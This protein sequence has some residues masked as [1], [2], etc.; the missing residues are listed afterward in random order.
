MVCEKQH[1]EVF[2]KETD[3]DAHSLVFDDLKP[4]EM[5]QVK[6]YLQQNLGV[7]LVD[8]PEAKSSDNCIY[9]IILQ[10]PPKAE[11]LKFLEHQGIRPTRQAL[12]VVYFGNQK[13]PNITEYVVGPL[14]EPMYHQDVTVQKYGGKLPYYR[15]VFLRTEAEDVYRFLKNKEYPKAPTFMNKVIAFNGTNLIYTSGMPPGLKSGDRKIWLTLY[16][17]VSGYTL[18]PTGLEMQMDVSSLDPSQWKVLKVFYNGQYFENMEDLE[19]QFNQG[20]VQVV[21]VKKVPSDGGY[22]SLKQRV[23][24]TGPGPLHYEPRGPRYRIRNNQV[25]FMSWSFTF[26][27]EANRGPRVF[28]IR[29][30]GERIVYEIS[31]QDASAIYG[32]NSPASMMTRYMDLSYGLG[33][34]AFSLVQGIDC[35]YLATYLDRH[36][37]FDSALPVTHKNSIC[38]FE[39]NAEMLLRRHFDRAQKPFYGGLVDSVLVFRSIITVDNYDYIS[40]FMFHQNGAVGVR[41]HASGYIQSAFYFG[42]SSEFGNRVEEWTLGAIHTHNINLKVDMDVGGVKNSLLANDMAFE[43][44]KAPWSPQNKI[45]RMRMVK[46]VLRTEDQAAFRLHEKMPNYI[47]FAANST[48]KWGLNRGYRIQ[49]VSFSGDHMPETDPMERAISWGRYKLAVT[50]RKESEPVS[51]CPYNQMDPWSPSVAFADFINNETIVNEDLVAWITVGFLHIPHSEDIPNTV[52]L[53][54]VI[55]FLLRPYNYYDDDPSMYS[56]DSVFLTSEQDPT[57][58]DVNHLACLPKVAA[59]L[60]NLPPFTYEGFQN[61]TKP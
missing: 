1:L 43:T 60:P 34:N 61:M 3:N 28:D 38:I 50:K 33:Y 23:P 41:V 10:L 31:L 9:S 36:Y 11:V 22:S 57:S 55:G 25:D 35:P 26:G 14:P 19:S 21:K 42:D 12:A 16:Q 29:F 53:G 45:H 49:I 18:H 2:S 4:G 24:H 5:I 17:N 46:K 44:V 39:E 51:T 47:Y 8:A 30:K 37:F 59:C 13:A 15:R 52:T 40:D 54:N 27:I 7:L 48:N 6:N 58:C 32:S 56:P 20:H